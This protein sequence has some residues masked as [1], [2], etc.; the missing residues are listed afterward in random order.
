LVKRYLIDSIRQLN[1]F[2][3]DGVEAGTLTQIYGPFQAGK[4]LLILQILY[5]W[6]SKGFGNALILDTEFS[7][8]NN[9]SRRW[10]SRFSKRFGREVS[11]KQLTLKK[12]V[13]QG[14]RRRYLNDITNVVI[15]VLTEL[16]IQVDRPFI[17][18]LLDH[19]IPNHELIPEDGGEGLGYIY[20][21]DV[22]GLTHLYELMGLE[23][24]VV[25]ED[26]KLDVVVRYRTDLYTSPLARFIEKYSVR[27][28]SLDSLGG[29]VKSLASLNRIQNFPARASALN[30]L[31]HNLSK[32]ANEYG[33]IVF[34]SNHETKSPINNFQ[35]FYGG[36]SVGY[37][38]K[39]TL[40][41]KRIKDL[42]RELIGYRTP[43]LPENRFRVLLNIDEGGF[44]EVSSDSG[45]NH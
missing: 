14:G 36:S 7:I 13:V 37:G 28:L 12:Y 6:V 2:F 27:F 1:E 9:F 24:K 40:Y 34:V 25:D 39:Y 29:L 38:F 20:I 15:E 30:I 32:L 43:H 45:E 33:L 42:R 19:L 17:R 18:R 44:H 22:K 41:I 5:E 10:L 11:F 21:L 3:M 26:T 31:L 4:S 23:S 35:T 8:M 16:D